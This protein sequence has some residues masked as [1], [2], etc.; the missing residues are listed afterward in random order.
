MTIKIIEESPSGLAEYAKVSIAFH[1]ESQLRVDLV[2][3]GLGGIRL[4]EEKIDPPYMRDGDA[5]WPT[6]PNQW[7]NQWDV[8]NWGIF[9]AFDGRERVGGAVVA[10]NTPGPEILRGG[11]L[12]AALWDIRV[13]PGQRGRGV[14]SQLFA[15]AAQWARS[16]GSR[17]MKVETNNVN[18]AACRFYTRHRCEL[19]SLSRLAYAGIRN[20][21]Q[22]VW[23]LD[24]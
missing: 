8:S 16:R 20:E 3:N 4:I 2:D 10:W 15:H 22:L 21:V 5:I 6:G 23:W 24:L 11:S 14:G 19:A 12:E 17:A 1:V 7:A 18:V 13:S 9:A